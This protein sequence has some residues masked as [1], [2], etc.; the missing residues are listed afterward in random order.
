MGGSPLGAERREGR[1][2]FISWK[3]LC[4]CMCVYGGDGECSGKLENLKEV[5]FVG[6]V[7]VEGGRRE[8][9]G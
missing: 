8:V 7:R 1:E 9:C 2:M 5:D 4:V 3:K 6:R